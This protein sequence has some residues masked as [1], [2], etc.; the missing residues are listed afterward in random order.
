MFCAKTW[1]NPPPGVQAR[2]LDPF[3]IKPLDEAALRKHAKAA[4]GRVVVVEDHY[5]A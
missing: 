3:T 2:V 4:G 5:Q 1:P